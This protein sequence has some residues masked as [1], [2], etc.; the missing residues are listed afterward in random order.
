MTGGIC[1]VCGEQYDLK[2]IVEHEDYLSM[3]WRAHCKVE[4]DDG[5]VTVYHNI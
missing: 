3:Q 5:T 1:P 2:E 4:N